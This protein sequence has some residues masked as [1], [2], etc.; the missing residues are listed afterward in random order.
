MAFN[1]LLA[2]TVIVTRLNEFVYVLNSHKRNFILLPYY[3][4]VI[5]YHLY[6]I[7]Q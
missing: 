6:L 7:I 3:S 4:K 5:A 1:L 2:I